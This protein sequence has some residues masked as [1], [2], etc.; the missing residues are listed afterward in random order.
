V[1]VGTYRGGLYHFADGKFTALRRAD[2]LASDTVRCLLL[3]QNND[4]W[5]ALESPNAVQRLRGFEFKN[6]HQPEA[7]RTVRTMA[8]D[9]AGN[10]WMGT[11]DGNLL[12]VAGDAIVDESARALRPIKPIRGLHATPDGTLWIG[13]AGAGLGILRNG[14][15]ARVDAEHGLHDNYISGI[16]S[17][18]KGALW[19]S[20]GHGIFNVRQ[21]EL[22]DFVVGK[23]KEV[24]SI[25]YGRNESVPNVQGSYGYS[26]TVARGRDGRVWFA[27]R[28]GIVAANVDRVQPN[29]MPPMILV[30]RVIVDGKAL[31]WRASNSEL[32]LPPN[33]RK[34]ELE[35]TALS[36]SAPEGV[37]FRHQLQQWDADWVEDGSL[38]R[39]SITYTR[40][41]AGDYK[42]NVTACND[43]GVWNET[44]AGLRFTVEPFFWQTVWFRIATLAAFTLSVV[45]IVRYVSFRRLRGRLQKLERE[46]SLNKERARIAKDIH[47]DVGASFAQ[48][49]L[50]GELAREDIGA[51]AKAAEHVENISR[52]ARDGINSLD[53]IVWAMNP[54]N[55]T[56]AHFLDYAGQY[57]VD[58]LRPAG[59]RCR[60]DF[61]QQPPDRA[62]GADVR[63]ELFLVIKESLH[64]IIKH[65]H[66]EEVWLRATINSTRMQ[67]SIEDNGQGFA[68]A[69][70][71]ALADGLRNMS[72]RLKAIGG[73]CEVTSRPNAGTHVK[74][75]LP[76]S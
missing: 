23:V 54:K 51:P 47:D 58:Y 9:A 49:A 55:D 68:S 46:A 6:Y 17:D 73:V 67:L 45:G 13:Y 71:N 11:Q 30:E 2:G 36:F 4:L 60:V 20:S 34:I 76:W 57:A 35:F 1:W 12:R 25:N 24:L 39:R 42:F 38:P 48:I 41:P 28:S 64:N 7:K 5:I 10:I 3:D 52:I 74:L 40:L 31:E 59:V 27:T 63:H 32:R 72:E 29:R 69:P 8:E 15:F 62:L 66:A 33:H 16:T 19:F 53:E 18:E 26:P 56:L 44:G 43:A 61:P 75:M 70:D 22:E 65:A 14:K 50:V 37:K 21:R